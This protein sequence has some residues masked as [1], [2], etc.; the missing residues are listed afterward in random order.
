VPLGEGSHDTHFCGVHLFVVQRHC[1]NDFLR[2]FLL[3]YAHH[4]P[5]FAA[6]FFGF[7]GVAAALVFASEW[8]FNDER[9]RQLIPLC[10][11]Q[12]GQ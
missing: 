3:S 9:C 5:P 10:A 11:A 8:P 12:C 7:M 4:Y 1:P 2:A 6:A